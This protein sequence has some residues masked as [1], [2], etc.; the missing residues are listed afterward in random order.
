MLFAGGCVLAAAWARRDA[1]FVP[2]VQP[3]L[4]LA[5]AVPAVVAA[6]GSLPRSGGTASALLAIGGPLI[7]G[8]PTLAITAAICLALGFIRSRIE[9]F[10]RPGD[11][12]PRRARRWS[13]CRPPCA[14]GP[15]AGP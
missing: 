8:F 13:A 1:L 4:L 2:M 6:T 14:P 12:R 11:D 7:N 10:Q 5:V 9:P 3:P 15:G